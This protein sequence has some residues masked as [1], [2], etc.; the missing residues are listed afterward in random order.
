VNDRIP[1]DQQPAASFRLRWS[2]RLAEQ[3]SATRHGT[4]TRLRQLVVAAIVVAAVAY[5]LA[6]A[7]MIAGFTGA[8]PAPYRVEPHYAVSPGGNSVAFTSIGNGHGD[9]YVYDLATASVTRLSDGPEYESTV[10]WSPDGSD[11]VFGRGPGPEGPL[12]LWR[13][14]PDGRGCR[15]LTGP[16]DDQIDVLPRHSPDG[17]RIAFAR[18]Y[19]RSG[20]SMG[21][22]GHYSWDVCMVGTDGTDLSRITE[23]ALFDTPRP[24]FVADGSAVLIDSKAFLERLDLASGKLMTL[25]L[26]RSSKVRQPAP[27]PDGLHVAFI[28]DSQDEF[29]SEVWWGTLDGAQAQPLTK[30]NGYVSWP[31]CSRDGNWVYFRREDPSRGQFSVWRVRIDNSATEEVIPD[32]VL[33]SPVDG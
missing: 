21:G 3:R 6:A 7:Y 5:A 25:R 20:R 10:S 23:L 2:D 29:R 1:T 4:W 13:C 18:S 31:E 26:P 16:D 22:V 9:L 27:S 11:I 8:L 15:A 12:A 14:D 28:G 32:T 19:R 33:M 17:E 24:M 30:L